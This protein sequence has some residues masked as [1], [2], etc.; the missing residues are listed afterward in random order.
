M[1]HLNKTNFHT[2]LLETAFKSGK[3]R[4][5]HAKSLLLI[6]LVHEFPTT[7]VYMC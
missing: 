7:L 3:C 1:V 6:E 2:Y 5:Y 4:W